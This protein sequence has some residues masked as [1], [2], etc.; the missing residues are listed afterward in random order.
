MFTACG[1]DGGG[2]GGPSTVPC[3]NATC[4][5]RQQ[6]DESGREPVCECKD[7]YS[8]AECEACADGY[9]ELNGVC[10]PVEID[11]DASDPCGASGTC[12]QETG[13]PDRCECLGNHTGPTCA[14]CEVGYQDNDQTGSCEVGC[15][16]QM[17]APMCDTPRLCDDATGS[18]VCVCPVGS[19]GTRCELCEDHYARRGDEACYKTCNHPDVA[20]ALPQHCFDD[21]GRQPASCV[22]EVGYAGAGCKECDAGFEEQGAYCV[23]SDLGG[24]DLLSVATVKGRAAIVGLNSATG[25]LTPLRSATGAEGLVYESGSGQLYIANYQG[26]LSLDLDS[27]ESTLIAAQQIGHGKPLAWDPRSNVLLTLRSSDYQLLAIDPSSGTV[28]ERGTTGSSWVWDATFDAD[29][30]TLYLLR[31]QGQTPSVISVNPDTAE[32]T[33]LGSV[34]ELGSLSSEALGGIAALGNGDLVITARQSMTN[35]EAVV[36]MC[37]DSADRLGLDGYAGAPASATV[38]GTGDVTLTSKATS[39]KEIVAYRSY[40]SSAPTTLT[41]DV[42]NPEAFLCIVTYEEDLNL[43]VPAGARWAGG[44]I[45][46]YRGSVTATVASGFQADSPLQLLGGSEATLDGAAA[47]PE[48]FRLLSRQEAADRHL[49]SLSDLDSYKRSNAPYR[50]VTVTPPALTVKSSVALEADLAGALSTF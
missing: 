19:T 40:S 16:N 41:L 34:V 50:L 24:S 1:S 43:S 23:R 31:S 33:E 44:L 30:T 32:A 18:A 7:A 5:A 20:C 11:C 28:S 8:G 21:G 27:G 29:S 39:G 22:C 36:A 9:E 10:S 46:D 15:D 13:K 17:E 25:A 45:Y 14:Q 42:D 2:G 26:A 47:H 35:E 37:R 12:V 3:G 6:C 38:D 49:V 48:A 4:S